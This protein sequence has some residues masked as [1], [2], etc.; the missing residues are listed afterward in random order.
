[1]IPQ[2]D[3]IAATAQQTGNAYAPKATNKAPSTGDTT[4]YW[5]TRVVKQ[6]K[7]CSPAKIDSVI[8]ANLPP[9]KIRWSQC[10][11]T[12]EI[13][14][15]EG[16]VPYADAIDNLPLCYELGYFRGNA[17][18]HPELTVRPLGIVAE[19]M[20]YHPK[21]DD[22][23]GSIILLCFVLA[24]VLLR[25]TR[26]FL[27][28]QAQEFL[29]PSKNKGTLADTSLTGAQN[30]T[31]LANIVLAAT[32]SLL[33]FHHAQGSYNLALCTISPYWLLAIYFGCLTLFFIAKTMFSGF[34]NWIFFDKTSRQ[35]WRQSYCFLFICETL[36][37]LPVTMS[38]IYFNLSPEVLLLVSA[39]IVTIFKLALLF[40]TYSIF[41][42]HFYG[43]LHL[44]SY[45]CALEIVPLLSLWA[46]LCGITDRLTITY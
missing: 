3:T 24:S 34:I 2:N 8:Q 26:R 16:R 13:P 5:V 20:P 7:G 21:N 35:Q 6:M 31:I 1:M 43:I 36:L 17:L 14:G 39:I 11:D 4:E 45:L 25:N 22:I 33:F 9:R 18:L 42:P 38:G 19:P 41:L 28:Q 29:Y 10:P 44:L 15:L 27:I 46:I 12:L 32:G 30:S 23:I 37:L 40:C